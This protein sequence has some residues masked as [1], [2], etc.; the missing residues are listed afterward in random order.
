MKLL[1]IVTIL[2]LNEAMAQVGK[3]NGFYTAQGKLLFDTTF[4]LTEYNP[5]KAILVNEE[6][7]LDSLLAKL[8]YFQVMKENG[9]EGEIILEISFENGI[10]KKVFC[11][12]RNNP[13]ICLCMKGD[14]LAK[15]LSPFRLNQKEITSLYIPVVFSYDSEKSHDD[16]LFKKILKTYIE[17][18]TNFRYDKKKLGYN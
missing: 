8:K 11:R 18:H 4:V 13:N 2:F 12:D 15:I 1:L 16:K 3:L 7:A 5:K 17:I 9:V 10:V 14:Y 6:Q